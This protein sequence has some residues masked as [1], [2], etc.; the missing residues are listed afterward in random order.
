MFQ[1]NTGLLGWSQV[2]GPMGQAVGFTLFVW[3]VLAL[4]VGSVRRTA[5]AASLS[6]WVLFLYSAF[7]DRI[8]AAAPEI[9]ASDVGNT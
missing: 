9:E 6:V 8:G 5:P 3:L 4:L 1:A 7:V 2:W